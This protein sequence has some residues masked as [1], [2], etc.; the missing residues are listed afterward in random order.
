MLCTQYIVLLKNCNLATVFAKTKGNR[1]CQLGNQTPHVKHEQLCAN[2]S[3][4]MKAA[5]ASLQLH[6]EYV[7]LQVLQNLD[8]LYCSRITT[9]SQ[10]GTLIFLIKIF[11]LRPLFWNFV[12]LSIISE[13][14]TVTECFYY[15]FDVLDENRWFHYYNR[16]T[17]NYY[18]IIFFTYACQLAC[19]L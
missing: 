18:K 13:G 1:F 7:S 5:R 12:V 11:C 6:A 16:A 9:S 3:V 14:S 17:F 19:V 2:M 10:G 8:C 15:R 4:I